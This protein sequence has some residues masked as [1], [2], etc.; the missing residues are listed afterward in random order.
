MENLSKLIVI[1]SLFF[2][3]FKTV[4]QYGEAT[5]GSTFLYR[6]EDAFESE[7]NFHNVFYLGF[8]NSFVKVDQNL[9][10]PILLGVYFEYKY[11]IL[12]KN[13]KMN[14]SV[15]G[16]PHGAFTTFFLLR[17]PVSINM[18]FF[19]MATTEQKYSGIGMSLGF[20]YEALVSTFD[21]EEYSPFVQLSFQVENIRVQYQYKLAN[22]LIVNHSITLGLMLDL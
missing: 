3:S 1:T 22:N 10:L 4:A 19:N 17:L 13:E 20:G 7:Y 16:Q 14:F 9:N 11:L 6:G 12:D 8:S 5:G 15:S 18:D 21:F 2:I